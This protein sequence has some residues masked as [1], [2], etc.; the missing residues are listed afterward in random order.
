MFARS[1]SHR[2]QPVACQRGG[3]GWLQAGHSYSPLPPLPARTTLLGHTLDLVAGH[4]SPLVHVPPDS[5]PWGGG[6][7]D[8]GGAGGGRTGAQFDDQPIGASACQLINLTV[9]IAA[10]SP[11]FLGRPAPPRSLLAHPGLVLVAGHAV[12]LHVGGVA[13]GGW[14]RNGRAGGWQG[15]VV[16]GLGGVANTEQQAG[17]STCF[18]GVGQV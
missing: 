5:A 16:D 13:H 11:R 8:C 12:L 4:A 3:R 15:F 7:G 9:G 14:L 6:G 2:P 1:S 10:P 17:L 18:L